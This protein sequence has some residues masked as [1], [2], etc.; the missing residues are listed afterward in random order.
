MLRQEELQGLDYWQRYGFAHVGLMYHL[1][2]KLFMQ[3]TLNG[4]LYGCNGSFVHTQAGTLDHQEVNL[5]PNV[6]LTWN[7]GSWNL[8]TRYTAMVKRPNANQLNPYRDESNPTFIRVGNPELRGSYTHN[9][10]I[11]PSVEVK[12]FTFPTYISVKYS[13][14]ASGNSI[15]PYQWVD[16]ENRN[17]VSY[18]NL[19]KYLSQTALLEFSPTFSKQ[20]SLTLNA[21]AGWQQSVFADGS[22]NANLSFNG[23]GSINYSF[24]KEGRCSLDC[25]YSPFESEVQSVRNTNYVSMNFKADYYNAKIKLGVRFK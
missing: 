1:H 20:L 15:V 14:T 7:I 24:S 4:E 9:I 6:N 5:L 18:A 12:I 8:S 21:G 17:I 16:Q 11:S 2:P 25:S 19:G 10:S 22:D 13:L 23:G 3:T